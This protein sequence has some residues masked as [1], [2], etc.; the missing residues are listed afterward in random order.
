MHYIENN[1]ALNF[2]HMKHQYSQNSSV[3]KA[4]VNNDYKQICHKLKFNLSQKSSLS[5]SHQDY[6]EINY[7]TMNKRKLV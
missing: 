2:N 5:N 3:A 1:K 7:K 4:N 6:I